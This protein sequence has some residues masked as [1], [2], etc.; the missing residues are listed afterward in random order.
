MSIH[1]TFFRSFI[2]VKSEKVDKKDIMLVKDVLFSFSDIQKISPIQSYIFVWRECMSLKKRGP[3]NLIRKF[4]VFLL[5]VEV[6][7]VSK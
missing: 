2:M 1:A 3:W 5:P 6:T 4:V 7:D